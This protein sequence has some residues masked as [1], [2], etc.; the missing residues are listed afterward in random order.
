MKI[1]FM[2]QKNA[3]YWIQTNHWST[4]IIEYTYIYFYM[5]YQICFTCTKVI[6]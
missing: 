4:H 6:I 2:N 5:Y 3:E 1:L